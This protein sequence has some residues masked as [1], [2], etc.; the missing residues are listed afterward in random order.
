MEGQILKTYYILPTALEFEGIFVGSEDL[1][2]IVKKTSL[3]TRMAR[4]KVYS[5]VSLAMFFSHILDEC[6]VVG[7]KRD[8]ACIAFGKRISRIWSQ[9]IEGKEHQN[10]Q[11][12]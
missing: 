9:A 10:E 3:C 6:Q 8:M 1:D 5:E 4:K 11:L 7:I 2:E 12:K